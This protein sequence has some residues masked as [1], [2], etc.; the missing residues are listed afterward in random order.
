VSHCRLVALA[1]SWSLHSRVLFCLRTKAWFH[2][3]FSRDS[4]N[5]D[6]LVRRSSKSKQAKKR[7]TASKSTKK[8]APALSAAFSSVSASELFGDAEGH[9]CSFFP[10]PIPNTETVTSILSLPN[11]PPLPPSPEAIISALK[12][13]GL[14]VYSGNKLPA[15]EPTFFPELQPQFDPASSSHAE[16]VTPLN[17]P[18]LG[19]PCGYPVLNLDCFGL[20]FDEKEPEELA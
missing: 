19:Y 15:V 17:A 4:P 2:P 10:I 13:L 20:D 11:S 12:S 14:N 18:S 9:G 6:D 5:L 16:T 7:Q 1:Q 3:S 8:S